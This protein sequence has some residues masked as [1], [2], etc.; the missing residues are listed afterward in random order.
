VSDVATVP[1][2]T[3]A[4]RG[5]VLAA[6]REP[7]TS[8]AWFA[9]AHVVVGAPIGVVTAFALLF[10]GPFTL[11]LAILP[12][13]WL[14]TAWQR[15]RFA[16]YLGV[17]LDRRGGPAIGTRWGRWLWREVRS[18]DTYRQVTYHLLAGLAA[19]TAAAVVLLLWS[20]GLMLAT[21]FAHARYLTPEGLFGL[22]V[23][24]PTTLGALTSA[25]ILM[26]FAAPWVARGFAAADVAVARAL[27][28]P[29][30]SDELTRRVESLAASRADVVAAADAER[31]RIERDL[32]DGTQQRLV[33]LAMNLGI[34][35]A[36][37][38]DLPEPARQAI[39]QAHEEAKQALLELRDFVRGLHPVVLDDRGLD[40]ALSG[41]AAR[42]PVPVRLKVAMTERASQTTEAIAYFV[43]SEALANV[44]KHAGASRVD[45]V[46][47]QP[48]RGWLRIEVVDDG[49]GGARPEAGTGLR[50]LAQ[51]VGSID[52]TF[53]LHS[54]VGGPTRIV[55]ELPCES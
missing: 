9:T 25:G 55:V 24:D 37:Q 31:R 47:G 5:A 16:A 38:T 45:V 32:H 13:T 6:L 36:T 4:W 17:R 49:R 14:F 2:G 44:A 41:I 26:I 48:L 19:T 7:W 18:A 29:N 12:C 23:H 20:G 50:G 40:A 15:A 51:R 1:D 3:A 33:S 53:S 11:G 43:V 27:L 54:P 39:A 22:R 46:V 28:E 8:R 10:L 30:S 42:S 34:A 52:G 35:R 21:T